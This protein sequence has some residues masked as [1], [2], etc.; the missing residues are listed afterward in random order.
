MTKTCEL[1]LAVGLLFLAAKS[2][3]HF[4]FNFERCPCIP[5]LPGRPGGQPLAQA[6]DMC[7]AP[8]CR[9]VIEFCLACVVGF[10]GEQTWM[11]CTLCRSGRQSM[12]TLNKALTRRV[13]WPT[14]SDA[15]AFYS[16]EVC[17]FCVLLCAPL[18]VDI[19]LCF[20]FF[21]CHHHH[22]RRRHTPSPP[23]SPSL[24]TA[25]IISTSTTTS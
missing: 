2:D 7:I 3:L 11:H 18:E 9:A 17:I 25:I 22:H 4:S 21:H 8:S 6:N 19:F 15:A 5:R 12:T 20:C 14:T 16:A 23:S 13:E 24:V 10:Q 1:A